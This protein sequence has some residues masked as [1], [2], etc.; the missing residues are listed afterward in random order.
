MNGWVYPHPPKGLIKTISRNY[1]YIKDSFP[2]IRHNFKAKSVHNLQ[3]MS[4]NLNFMKDVG[5]RTPP[6]RN[7]E[8]RDREIVTEKAGCF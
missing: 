8:G 6:T 3:K 4:K 5:G 1:R 7:L 2:Y